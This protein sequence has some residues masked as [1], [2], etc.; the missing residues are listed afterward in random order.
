MQKV[1]VIEIWNAEKQRWD[2]CA[3][4]AIDRQQADNKIRDW[5]NRNPQ[6]KFRAM[7]YSPTGLLRLAVK[8]TVSQK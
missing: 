6:D 7:S 2:S 8:Q 3:D 5:Q 4:A 1:F